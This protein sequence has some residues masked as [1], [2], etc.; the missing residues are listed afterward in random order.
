[1]LQTV[2]MRNLSLIM[3]SHKVIKEKTTI[4]GWTI[5]EI[6]D[7]KDQIIGSEEMIN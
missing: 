7:M 3:V 1:M 5:S 4:D 2:S 6:W